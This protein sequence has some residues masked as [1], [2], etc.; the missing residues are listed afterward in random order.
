M[1][2]DPNKATEL[3]HEEMIAKAAGAPDNLGTLL[4]E[5]I[6]LESHAYE[7][8]SRYRAE[9]DRLI[10]LIPVNRQCAP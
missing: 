4:T 5:A 7:E 9:V 1:T 2:Y 10:E 6:I 3:W 8:Y